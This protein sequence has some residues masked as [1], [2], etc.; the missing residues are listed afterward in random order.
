MRIKGIIFDYNGVFSGADW[1][2][3]LVRKKLGD[4]FP[5]RELDF[6]QLANACDLGEISPDEFKDKVAASLEITREELNNFRSTIYDSHDYFRKDLVELV[7]QLKNTYKIAMLSNYSSTTLLPL[8]EKYNL[9]RLFDYV[10]ISSEMKYIKPDPDAFDFVIS[11]LG[12]SREEVL[13]VDDNNG[14]A[15]AARALGIMSCTFTDTDNFK[16]YLQ[17]NDISIS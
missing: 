17:E 14:H 6:I 1:Y 11:K 13:F 8:L 2:W 16:Q 3:T 12:L 10:G 9:E 15:D 4:T 5:Q 7:E